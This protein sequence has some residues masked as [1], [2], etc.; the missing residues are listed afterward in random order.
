M[1]IAQHARSLRTLSLT[2]CKQLTGRSAAHLLAGCCSKLEV[3]C[4]DHCDQVPV[5]ML[6]MLLSA[7]SLP[8]PATPPRKAALNQKRRVDNQVAPWSP[9]NV[10]QPTYL[11]MIEPR[12]LGEHSESESESDDDVL[13]HPNHPSAE[14]HSRKLRPFALKSLSART[15]HHPGQERMNHAMIEAECAQNK[16][17]RHE[18]K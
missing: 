13:W 9:D 12:P 17:S 1:H 3:L 4:L 8:E 2:Y 7:A 5:R 14:L 15:C 18:E 16:P 6:N 10:Q 11:A